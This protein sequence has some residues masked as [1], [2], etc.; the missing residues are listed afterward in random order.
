[1]WLESGEESNTYIIEYFF[2]FPTVICTPQY[3]KWFRSYAIL[4][5]TGLLEFVGCAKWSNLNVLPQIQYNFR[6]LSI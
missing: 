5:S 1:M 4:N 6:I 3:D 2:L